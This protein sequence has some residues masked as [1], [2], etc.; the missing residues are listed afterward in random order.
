MSIENFMGIFTLIFDFMRTHGIEIGE[1]YI[2]IMDFMLWCMFAGIIIDG[3]L[4]ILK[5]E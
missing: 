3:I 2:S 4:Y 5:G 1:I